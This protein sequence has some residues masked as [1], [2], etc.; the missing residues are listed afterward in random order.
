ME[1]TKKVGLF[2]LFEPKWSGILLRGACNTGSIVY[3]TYA[4]FKAIQDKENKKEK[5]KWLTY[6]SVY[7]ALLLLESLSDSIL[8]WFPYYYHAK[9][10]LL[11]WLL[12]PETDGSRKLYNQ[13]MKPFFKRFEPKIDIIVGHISSLMAFIYATHRP[14]IERAWETGKYAFQQGNLMYKWLLDIDEKP[15]DD[16]KA[17]NDEK[18]N[19]D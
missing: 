12:N 7:G 14:V 16:E 13:Y 5:E 10:A 4:S 3:P 19:I 2:L 18:P 11:I 8:N 17:K 9:F 15:K 1:V 6:W